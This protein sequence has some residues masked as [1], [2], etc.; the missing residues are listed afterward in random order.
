M[1]SALFIAQRMTAV[2][3][4]FAV[5]IHLVTIIYAAQHGLT[6]GHILQRTHG[7]L[8]FLAL[9]ST[10]V[11]AAAIHGPIGLRNILREW[12]GWWGHRI[13]A[14]LFAFALMLLA[15]GLRAAYGVFVA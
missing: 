2:I 15:L 10:F 14:S 6:A 7:N 8:A 5:A 9:Y 12:L 3:L 11:I 13:D 1:N 4:A